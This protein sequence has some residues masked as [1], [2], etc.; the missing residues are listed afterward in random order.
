MSPGAEAL[1]SRAVEMLALTGRGLDRAIKVGRTIA[2][3]AGS[4]DIGSDHLAEALSY[5]SGFGTQELAR[6]G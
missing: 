2:D 4:E 5:R 1:L 6:A 3:L